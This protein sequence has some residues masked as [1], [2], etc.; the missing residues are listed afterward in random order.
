MVKKALDKYK[1]DNRDRDKEMQYLQ[2]H[3]RHEHV[4]PKQLIINFLIEKMIKESKWINESNVEN[5]FNKTLKAAVV[6]KEENDNAL[7]KYR[8][9]MPEDIKAELDN[10]SDKDTWARY[11]YASIQ[12]MKVIWTDRKRNKTIEDGDNFYP[13]DSKV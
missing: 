7:N 9:K 8:D 4:V 11:N 1:N 6:T 10:Y 12:L 3:F 13:F 2:K 5:L